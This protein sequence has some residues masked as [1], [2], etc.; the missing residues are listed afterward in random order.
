MN[1]NYLEIA[2]RI[3]L[4]EDPQSETIATKTDEKMQILIFNIK[5]HDY[6]VYYLL[7]VSEGSKKKYSIGCKY[8]IDINP[9]EYDAASLH[10]H[11]YFSN[12]GWMIES[13][14]L[15]RNGEYRKIWTRLTKDQKY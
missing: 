12:N 4:V 11:I 2:N 5:Y 9:E 15:K 14:E 13:F 10:G 6:H 7:A 1:W 8:N 3:L